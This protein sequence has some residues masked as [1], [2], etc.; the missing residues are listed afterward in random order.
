MKK[1]IVICVSLL[2]AAVL[3]IYVSIKKNTLYDQLAADR[4][5]DDG[6][7]AQISLF[8]P[9]RMTTELDSMFFTDLSHRIQNALD[10]SAYSEA[11]GKK[12]KT[13]I[14]F[15]YS[16]SV[17]GEALLLSD[18]S[19]VSVKTYGVE[20][21]FFTFH[22][23]NLLTGAYLSPDDLMEDG[24]ILDE[25]AAWKLF[26][27]SDI[28]GQTVVLAGVPHIAKGVTRKEEGV[29]AKEAGLDGPMCYMSL[30]SLSKYGRIYGSYDYEM[31]LPNPVEG[32]A[33]KTVSEVLGKDL[34]ELIICE[35]SR[36]FKVKEL[37]EIIRTKKLRSMSTKGAVF[38]YY[39]NIA[40]SWEDTF[41]VICLTVIIIL[42]VNLAIFAIFIFR[43]LRS[44]TFKEFKKRLKHNIKILI[45][46]LINRRE[47][48]KHYEEN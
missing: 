8:Y 1:K 27:S 16:V 46:E 9:V 30:D 24:I 14:S 11:A 35:N 29:V 6:D 15:P 25:D 7:M 39:E 34:E 2:L 5:T 37:V 44:Q 12:D 42:T 17:T 33:K 19:E 20:G 13:G 43:L 26:G 38:P 23:V 22:P 36:R 40:R 41:S 18:S 31:I 48:K 32:F 45:S 4:W 47:F 3:S 21:D 28:A 10:D